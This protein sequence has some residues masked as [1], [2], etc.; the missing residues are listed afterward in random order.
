M[1]R[2]LNFKRC[3]GRRLAVVLMLFVWSNSI[4]PLVYSTFPAVYKTGLAHTPV[5]TAET[6]A[7]SS[8][9]ANEST[10]RTVIEQSKQLPL[11]FEVNQGQQDARVKFL[12]RG[13]GYGLFLTP[14]ETVM[15]LGKSAHRGKRDDLRTTRPVANV[16]SE[17]LRMKLVNS[18]PQARMI[19]LEELPGKS[20]YFIGNDPSKW[21]TDVP[22]YAKVKYEQVY[23]G[24]DLIYY[25]NQQQL[26]YD[27]IVSPGADPSV[28]RLGYEGA[29]RIS[30]N[31][32]GDLIL[33]LRNGEVRQQKPVLYQLLDDGKQP[34]NGRYVITRKNQIGI[35]VGAYDKTKALVIDPVVAYATFLGG[36]STNGGDTAYDIDID[37]SGNAYV[38]GVTDSSDFPTNNPYQGY[39]GGTCFGSLPCSDAFVTKINASGS[40]RLYS[41]YIGGNQSD[42]GYGLRVDA[43]GSAYITGI[44]NSP[45]FPTL[46][47]LQATLGGNDDAF[48][49]KLSATGNALAYATYLGGSGT[50][51]GQAIDVDTGGNAYVT[52]STGSANFPT[53]N[54]FQSALGNSVNLTDVFVTKLNAS[55]NALVY[56]TYLGGNWHDNGYAI[57]VD[58][59]GSA[60][61]TGSVSSS[62]FP[63]AAALYPTLNGSLDAFVTKLSPLGNSL[64][65]ST[66][67]GGPSGEDRGEGI[68]LDS[69]L[70]VYVTGWAGF[71]F[72]TVNAYDSTFGG[73]NFPSDAFLTKI[74]ATGG[75]L[76]Y[77]TFLGG[78]G[79]DVG[80]GVA[81]DASGNAYVVG[82]T[83]STSTFPRV[84]P[85]QNFFGG[86][87]SDMFIT[88]FD[89]TGNVTFSTYLGGFSN[90]DAYA[91]AVD[92]D[93]NAY[94]A[95]AT[96]SSN[97]PVKNSL[98]T[99]KGGGD[100]VV[101]KI[102]GLI[103]FNITGRVTDAVGGGLSAVTM[104]LSGSQTGTTQT[105]SGGF[106]T[107]ADLA[108]GGNY[109]VTPSKSPYTFVPANRTF[110]NLTSN[111]TGDF[112]V[113][114]YSISG[115][116]T[117]TS[118]AG[119]SGVVL[120]L[121]GTQA[122]TT[123]TDANGNYSFTSVAAGGTYTVT[124]SKSD[125]VLTYTFSPVSR[126]IANLNANTTLIDFTASTSIVSALNPIADAYVQD[127]SSA[128]TNFG[129]ATS[130]LVRT[131]N[132]NNNGL[133]RDAYLMF[134]LDGVSGSIS[135][136]KLR[137]Y[138][139]LSQAGTV[140]TQAYSTST[141][142][143][144]SGSGSITWNNK[145]IKNA[146]TGATVVVNTTTF[147]TYDIDVTNYVRGEKLAG[148]NK[149]SLVL[150]DPSPV[151][152][153]FT[154]NSREAA[155]NKP[156]L[157]VTTS[158]TPNSAPA[159]S[160]TS[161]APGASFTAPGSIP[162]SSNPS[163]SDGSISSVTYYAGTQ[164][165][166]SSTT[167]PSYQ[168]TWSPVPAGAYTLYAVATDNNGATTTSSS[169]NITV[170]ASNNAPTVSLESP[171]EGTIFPAGSNIGL[172]AKAADSDGTLSKVEFF[173]GTTLVGTATTPGPDNLYSVTWNNVASGAYALTAKAT[174][175]ANGVTPS[176]P[177]VTI[178]VVSQT[179]LSPLFDAYVRDGASAS[180]N[181]GTATE[182]QVQASATA[183]S[184]R[185][186]HLRF[187][188]QSVQS[189]ARAKLRLYGKLSDTS[190]VN[191]PL[192]VYPV[193]NTT[194]GET[195]INWNTRPSVGGLLSSTTITD[196]TA[197]WYEFDVTSY[198][199]NERDNLQ[200]T[201]VSLAVKS[202]ANSS[203]Y[204]TFSSREATLASD[205]RPQ[206]IIWT[207]QPRNALL[208]VGSTNLGTGDNAVKTR[209]QNLGFTVTAKVANNSLL[210]TDADGKTVVVISSTVTATSVGS[211][212][213]H[214]AVP[215]V[216]WEFDVFDDMAMTGTISGTDFGTTAASNLT[217]LTIIN[218]THPLAAGLSLG[219]QPVNGIGSSYAWGNPNTNP[220][221]VKIATVV[222]DANKFVIFGY[223]EGL[224]MP[225]LLSPARRVG[226]FMTDVTANSFNTNGGSLFD[227]AIK[228][229][230]EL[231]T[232]PVISSVTPSLGPSGTTVTI[233][234]INFGFTQGTS[235]LN[236][237][238]VP[239]TPTTWTD[240]SI[241]STVPPFASTGPIVVTVSGVASNGVVFAIGEIDTDADGLPDNWEIQYFG[242]L[243][244]TASGDPDGDGLTNLLEYQQGRNPTKSAL[245]DPGDFVNLKVHS[246]LS[247]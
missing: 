211:K 46:N 186:S 16:P 182:L 22:N 108:A 85:L 167:G 12:S 99:L 236:F 208:V 192:G 163:D 220:N 134:D 23:S 57:V 207:T 84:R 215:V 89:S 61:I 139:A 212:F 159:I 119:E 219:N 69:S 227:A 225:G 228:W 93:G 14:E 237:N 221:A 190:G 243:N 174:D 158:A 19:G 238:G 64:V 36:S 32:D 203:P 39:G 67:L 74:D 43:S 17:V 129:T 72:P 63:V 143:K 92:N 181:F 66:Y 94:V 86:G 135:S 40:A 171:L 202:L 153:H 229:A 146:L 33:K 176:S 116:V 115:R 81:V 18:N 183:G 104:T 149:V 170:N 20:N 79:D 38:I 49:V 233:K 160:I 234:G 127:G 161:P 241:V 122:S 130:M 97:F 172:S 87:V 246:P 178:S 175:N 11:S 47:P 206:L 53:S 110:N 34:V 83:L 226:L 35:E 48:V 114:A 166:G 216:N 88:M 27:L 55:G 56:S 10:R 239:A 31:R 52:G 247:P 244:Q 118:S 240:K 111:Q 147:V 73:G 44:T 60:Y 28:I 223:D 78:S 91:I 90:D 156:R 224:A 188:L 105:D 8:S 1:R 230:T 157:V 58:S 80:D 189:I 154:L 195:S 184:N 123:Q 141:T 77:S 76:I 100:A 7:R 191:V 121:S 9:P 75:S 168:I 138:A 95:G 2:L 96:I 165:I 112:T 6:P 151:T 218:T 62:D 70:N 30:I 210:S 51:Q 204:A 54:A 125:P 222:G 140:T 162:I 235:T 15:V 198:V 145:P 173:A 245:S 107:F 50:D 124:P 109:T 71:N 45:N 98:Q 102:T 136:V 42:Y 137:F 126:N 41:T 197:R 152:P 144:E 29:K 25:G 3:G 213:R 164:S 101:L 59:L 169:V 179:G 155:S 209:L 131:D 193:S 21:K 113:T 37:A 103:S 148:R 65:F 231:I 180:T 128:N 120:T 150:H 177:A 106:Y 199:K 142:W 4:C 200:H 26:E 214:A 185:E 242:N 13:N 205:I 217:Q 194:W 24:I 117:N 196:N 68:A 133:N 232:K 132:Q 201:L 187:D 5:T 82:S